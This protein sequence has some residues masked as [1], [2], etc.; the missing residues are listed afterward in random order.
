METIEEETSDIDSTVKANSIRTIHFNP[1]KKD[2]YKASFTSLS[3]LLLVP[4]VGSIYSETNQI[5]NIG[6]RTEGFILTIMSSWWIVTLI[7]IVY[8]LL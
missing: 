8:V 6:E 5:F 3:F 4:L 1:T 7:I 2:I